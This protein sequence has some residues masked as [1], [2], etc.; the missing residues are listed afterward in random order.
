MA[1]QLLDAD[2]QL[3]VDEDNTT[4]SS[5]ASMYAFLRHLHAKYQRHRLNNQE[6]QWKTQ[7]CNEDMHRIYQ[8]R[9]SQLLLTCWCL[10]LALRCQP[11]QYRLCFP[12]DPCPVLSRSGACNPTQPHADVSLKQAACRQSSQTDSQWGSQHDID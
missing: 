6:Q 10:S 9:R 2:M 8:Q 1:Q 12:Y 11:P 5:S 3:S 7:S 4:A